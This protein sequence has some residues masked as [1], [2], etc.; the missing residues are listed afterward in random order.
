MAI[1]S[2]KRNAEICDYI[3]DFENS[4]QVAEQILTGLRI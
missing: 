2:E 3:V 1:E 4:D